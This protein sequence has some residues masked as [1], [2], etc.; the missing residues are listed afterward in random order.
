MV[1]HKPLT[2]SQNLSVTC[3]VNARLMQDYV[4]NAT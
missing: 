3:T 4:K 2:R 1:M